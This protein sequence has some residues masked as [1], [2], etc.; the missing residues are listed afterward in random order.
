M[1]SYSQSALIGLLSA[2]LALSGL[3]ACGKGKGDKSSDKTNQAS[4]MTGEP[5]ADGTMAAKTKAKVKA[6]A[7][8]K[9]QPM[10]EFGLD[11]ADPRW[12]GWTV[13]G[14]KKAKVMKD[15]YKGARLAANGPG[16][17]NRKPG[18]DQGFDIAFAQLK[19]PR[20][21]FKKVKKNLDLKVKYSKGKMKYTILK[22]EADVITWTQQRGTSKSYHLEVHLKVGG[23]HVLCRSNQMIGAGNAAELARY[24]TG[25]KSLKKK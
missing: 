25:C 4:G 9:V 21:G 2:S 8:A 3:V 18:G 6:K 14:P 5:K 24:L 1:R 12:K 22:E 7:K 16:M 17:M 13:Q 15:G 20:K 19:K 10:I 11:S 23:K